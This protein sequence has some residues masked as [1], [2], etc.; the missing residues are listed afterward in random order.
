MLA[1]ICHDETMLITGSTGRIGTLLRKA[2]QG[3]AGPRPLWLARRCPAD[4]L[5]SPGEALPSVLPR[6]DTVIALWGQISGTSED[7]AA[8]VTLVHHGASLARACGARRMLHLSSAAVYGPGTALTEDTPPRPANAYGHAKLAMEEAVRA[9]PSDETRH[10]CLRLANV[11]GA[12]SLAP[13][14]RAGKG[15]VRLD[16]FADG[17]GPLRSYIAPGDLAQVLYAL[18]Q[19]PPDRL[20]TRLNVT[21]P[22]PVTMESLVRAADRPLIWQEAPEN[23]VQAVTLDGSS[24]AGLLPFLYLKDTAHAMIDDWHSLEMAA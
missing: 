8:N 24:L 1:E 18:A 12:D 10:C 13:A 9:L 22:V 20:P 5:W 3:P 2:W 7:L 16:R 19:L 23:A 11:V 17:T 6:C 15:P 14:L 21:A 4:I